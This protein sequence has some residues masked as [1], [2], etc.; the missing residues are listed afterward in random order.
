M[1]RAVRIVLSLC[2]L[3][4][5]GAVW[6]QQAQ[7]KATVTQERDASGA[8]TGRML[9]RVTVENAGAARE[10]VFRINLPTAYGLDT[11]SDGNISI[12]DVRAGADVEEI[13]VG[14]QRVKVCFVEAVAGQ[15]V[16]GLWIVALLQDAPTK[17]TKHVCDIVFT[18]RG[19]PTTAPVTYEAQSIS[20]KDANLNVLAT[21]GTIAPRANPLFGDLDWKG[22]INAL[23]FS[24]FAQAWRRYNATKQDLALADFYPLATGTGNDPNNDTS[25]GDRQVNAL[26]FAK[27]AQAWRA[28]NQAHA[29]SAPAGK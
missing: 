6:A 2:L 8:L 3:M 23:D 20:V 14:S 26:D 15:G 10:C 27:F 16:S 22:D 19:R 21:T 25:Q 4:G 11:A 1:A 13:V 17:T 7:V 28:Y 29:G 24:L 5:L 18:A 9:M 12:K